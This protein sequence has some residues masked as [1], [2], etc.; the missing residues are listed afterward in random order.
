MSWRLNATHFLKACIFSLSGHVLTD[1]EAQLFEQAQPLGFILFKRNID[2]PPQVKALTD[3]IKQC[4]GWDCPI[5]IDQEGGRVARLQPPIWQ[6]TQPAAKFGEAYIENKALAQ[7]DMEDAYG[8]IARDLKQVGISVN[9]APVLDVRDDKTSDAI[10]DRSYSKNPKIVSQCG[11][12]VCNSFLK[13]AITPVIK[14]MP[15][16]GKARVDSHFELPFIKDSF[17]KLMDHDFLPFRELSNHPDC[18]KIWGMT[19]HILMTDLDSEHPASISPSIIQ[20]VIRDVLGFPGFLVSDD[21]DM[22]GLYANNQNLSNVENRAKAIL[23][24]GTDAV[25]YCSGHLNDMKSLNASLPILTDAAYE[26]LKNSVPTN[27]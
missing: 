21:I 9:C 11:Q 3:Q 16:H 17:D 22:K 12:I 10:G 8:C 24:A 27:S 6:S 2:N 20:D 4:V 5:L 13:N 26:R 15:G 19:A 18:H 23:E 14:H 7:Y 25:L 1:D